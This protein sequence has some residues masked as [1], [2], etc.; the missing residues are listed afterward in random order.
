MWHYC[1]VPPAYRIEY[2]PAALRDAAHYGA[3]VVKRVR[4]ACGVQ[5]RHEPMRE[6]TNRFRAQPNSFGEYELRVQPLRVYYD[7][8]LRFVP[9]KPA[10]RIAPLEDEGS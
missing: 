5:L 3:G 6:T 10:M 7:V 8:D 9:S 2:D 4:Q 1:S